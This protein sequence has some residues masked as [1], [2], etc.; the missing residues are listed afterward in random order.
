MCKIRFYSLFIVFGLLAVDILVAENATVKT[1][2]VKMNHSEL[3]RNFVKNL[4]NSAIEIINIPEITEEEVIKKFTDIVESNFAVDSM[5][6]FSLGRHNRLLTTLQ[7]KD[8]LYCFINM[9]IKL[10]VSNFREYKT[11]KFNIVSV[12][13]KAK[14]H[15]LIDSK[16]SISGKKDTIITWFVLCKNGTPKIYNAVL[17]EVSMGQILRA[18]IQGSIA[19]KGL[20]KFMK[21][22]KNKYPPNHNAELE[23]KMN[24]KIKHE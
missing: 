21:E 15:Y 6:K 19:E 5:A 20:D 1:S 16:V 18:E 11:A 4:G 3:C 17:N 2:E 7:K 10:Y 23:V 12:K 24:S 14:S 13:K 8:F 22:F 9:L